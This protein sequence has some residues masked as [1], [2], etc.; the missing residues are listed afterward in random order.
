M[1]TPPPP[2]PPPFF[3]F[4]PS[5]ERER[6]REERRGKRESKRDTESKRETERE[7]D[8]E[9]KRERE[10]DMRFVS[11]MATL[12]ITSL[13]DGP[14]IGIAQHP[15]PLRHGVAEFKCRIRIKLAEEFGGACGEGGDGDVAFTG[16][17]AV[18]GEQRPDLLDRRQVRR[19]PGPLGFR[20]EFR[21]LGPQEALDGVCF[22]SRGTV[23]LPD[24]IV[25][26][27][28]ALR[29]GEHL[30]KDWQIGTL[31]NA[32]CDEERTDEPNRRKHAINMQHH[33]RWS[34][35][36][37]RGNPVAWL[38]PQPVVV[39]VGSVSAGEWHRVGPDD[40]PP[41]CSRSVAVTVT[42]GLALLTVKVRDSRSVSSETP[43]KP[44]LLCDAP[45]C[46]LREDGFL[47]FRFSGDDRD[48]LS[49]GV[50]VAAQAGDDRL[51]AAQQLCDTTAE[52]WWMAVV[53]AVRGDCV[54]AALQYA[55]GGAE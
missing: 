54:V 41:K 49:D 32:A 55:V 9:S 12:H 3:S 6:A 31:V 46:A 36:L 2:P 13:C 40:T 1:S 45:H 43:P 44:L 52:C 51:G 48:D 15:H 39:T 25:V 37:R 26:S 34:V 14:V 50:S 47:L 27:E 23:L 28:Q 53:S 16:A 8:T 17:L 20:N 29:T 30:L 4:F 10:K 35:F 21:V 5:V 18:V 24:P 22:V 7:R 19:V 42:E 38:H 33:R 11:K